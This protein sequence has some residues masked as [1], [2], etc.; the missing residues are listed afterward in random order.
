MDSSSAQEAECM[1]PQAHENHQWL[2]QLVGDWDF[3]VDAQM[4]PDQPSQTMRGTESVR[5][6]GELWII[7]EGE[8]EMPGG[9][10]GQ[11]RMTLGYDLQRGRFVGS[12]IGSMMTC[13]WV[14]DGELDAARQVLTLDTEGP[15]FGG[16]GKL[17]R[18]QDVIELI[19]A[20]ER[21]L[22]SRNLGED[23]QWRQFMEAR[24]RRRT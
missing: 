8:G 2:L 17:E 11:T 20:D 12:W 4:E 1:Q 22:R 21:V 15:G 18:Y 5:A 16:Q 10:T 3:E 23:G 9:G 14:Y 7:A 6:L 19:S 24:Y 13:L